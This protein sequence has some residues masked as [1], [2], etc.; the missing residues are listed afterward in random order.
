MLHVCAVL[1]RSVVSSSLQPCELYSLSGSSVLGDS[2]GKNTGMCSLA[3]LQRI[4]PT[5]VSCI[6]GELFTILDTRETQEYW[7]GS[8]SL[9]KE[10]FLT[11]QLNLH[12]LCLLHC[13]WILY[14]LN[15]YLFPD[16]LM[17]VWAEGNLKRLKKLE[18]LGDTTSPSLSVWLPV[19]TYLSI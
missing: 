4:F 5:H 18:T 13:R 6:T 2:P 8:L 11:Q 14:P 17:L 7:S 19:G 3:L 15:P 12:L 1:S 16:R 9:L 10:I